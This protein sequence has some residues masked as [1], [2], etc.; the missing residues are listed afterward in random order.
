V[1]TLDASNALVDVPEV[2]RLSRL[3]DGVHEV[4]SHLAEAAALGREA[5]P[6]TRAPRA[7]GYSPSIEEVLPVVIAFGTPAARSALA[8]V[9]RTAWGLPA[10]AAHVPYE[11]AIAVVLR[12]VGGE[13]V[14][15]DEIRGVLDR[16]AGRGRDPLAAWTIGLVRSLEALVRRHE[17]AQR[18]V[19]GSHVARGQGVP[20]GLLAIWALAFYRLAREAGLDVELDSP[21]APLDVL[22]EP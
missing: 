15:A 2:G 4:R 22:P 13:R 17:L 5:L 16:L 21:Y 6:V 8:R 18:G 20:R 7:A 12:V 9:P 11:D 10:D 14:A 3:T 1:L 19:H